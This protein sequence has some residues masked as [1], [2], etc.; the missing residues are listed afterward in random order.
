MDKDKKKLVEL[1]IKMDKL[2]RKLDKITKKMGE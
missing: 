2:K 1:I